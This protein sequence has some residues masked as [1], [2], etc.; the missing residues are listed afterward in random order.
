MFWPA[1]KRRFG[2]FLEPACDYNFGSGHEKSVGMSGG[3]LIAIPNPANLVSRVAEA[4][5]ASLNV[6]FAS[7][8]RDP[9]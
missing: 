7:C 9:C 1:E 4:R 6:S 2:L 8:R 5:H 3:V